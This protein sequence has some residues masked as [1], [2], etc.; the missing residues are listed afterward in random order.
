MPDTAPKIT[1]DA[2]KNRVADIKFLYHDHLTICV[3]TVTNGFMVV[4]KSAPASPANYD[5][6]LGENIAFDD[7]IKQLWPLEG[8]L[9]REKLSQQEV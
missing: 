9:L 6:C 1:E 4:G 2:I 8:Y 7:A 5:R 3:L